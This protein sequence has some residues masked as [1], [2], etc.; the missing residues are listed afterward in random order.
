M[1]A[2]RLWVPRGPL[3][4]QFR[5]QNISMDGIIKFRLSSAEKQKINTFVE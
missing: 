3:G 5:V 2:V 4:K 1:V